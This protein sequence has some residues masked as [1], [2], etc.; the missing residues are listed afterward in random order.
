MIIAANELLELTDWDIKLFGHED[1]TRGKLEHKIKSLLKTL[2]S[3]HATA[4]GMEFTPPEQKWTFFPHTQVAALNGSRGTEGLTTG[5][6]ATSWDANIGNNK[7][8]G[9]W[10]VNYIKTPVDNIIDTRAATQVNK[11]RMAHLRN[12]HGL[13]GATTVRWHFER[14]ANGILPYN[15]FANLNLTYFSEV[16]WILATPAPSYLP[17]GP[18]GCDDRTDGTRSFYNTNR[19]GQRVFGRRRR[20]RVFGKLSETHPVADRVLLRA[21]KQVYDHQGEPKRPKVHGFLINTPLEDD[22][23]LTTPVLK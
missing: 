20:R 5:D 2:P 4:F 7:H 18:G 13:Y 1:V 12:T 3:T 15:Y 19:F 9:Q 8:L 11:V 23:L 10:P 14:K 17:I 21:M 6:D 22:E 16:E